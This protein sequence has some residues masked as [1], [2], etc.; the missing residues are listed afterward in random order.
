M[1]PDAVDWTSWNTPD[2]RPLAWD[3]DA[4][5]W[6]P[7]GL[8]ASER[9]RGLMDLEWP[10]EDGDGAGTGAVADAEEAAVPPA[11]SLRVVSL[12]APAKDGAPS[13]ADVTGSLQLAPL[14][15]DA[16]ADDAPADRA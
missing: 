3:W 12:P 2:G 13:P 10:E 16:A 15:D 7:V 4:V 9:A 5:T 6:D 1:P 14:V 11:T 8:S